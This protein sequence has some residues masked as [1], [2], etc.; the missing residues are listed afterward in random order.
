MDDLSA[1]INGFESLMNQMLDKL[2][3][4]EAWKSTA[5]E[6][7]DRLLNQAER[8]ALRLQRLEQLEAQAP[9]PPFQ[10]PRPSTAPPPPPSRWPDPFDLNTAPQQETRPSASSLE[11]PSGHHVAPSHRDAGGGILGSHPPHP[12]T[13]MFHDLNPS[14]SDF[15]SHPSSTSVRAPHLPKLEFPKFDGDNPR[16]WRDHCNMYFEVYSVTPDLKT[17]F[18]ALNFKGAAATWLQTFERRGRVTDWDTFCSTVFDHFDKNQYQL[19]LRQLDALKQTGLVS[20]YLE[21]FEQLS[22]GVL[23]YNT[24]YDDTYFVTRF[25]GGL[26]E[27]IRS[28]IALHRPKDVQTASALALLQEEELELRKKNG[29]RE[30]AKANYRPPV[31]VD[32]FKPMAPDKTASSKSKPDKSDSDE[33]WKSL[34]AF[35]R[36]NGLCYKC[37]EKWGH[38]HKCPQQVSL[39]VIEELW[40]ALEHSD[41]DDTIDSD[42]EPELEAVLAVD[43][44]LDQSVTK[45]RTMKLKGN[46]GNQEVLI[47]IDSGSVG[48]FVS[49]HLADKL[50]MPTS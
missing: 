3:G 13:G 32:K 6:A 23:L 1:K 34:M 29:S 24:H 19:Q 40:D 35:R 9:P 46:V 27:E 43:T 26:S 28:V 18:A 20:E 33:K 4:L 22:H 45:R 12:V 8:M 38:N 36:K 5:E 2:T 47:L 17:R 31:Q 49:E 7:S 16:L 48:T 11:R 41:E 44:N 10:Q 15:H 21:R 25:L 39:H 14:D 30:F 37:G 42:D 50:Q